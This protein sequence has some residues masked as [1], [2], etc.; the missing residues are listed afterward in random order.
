MPT[1]ETEFDASPFDAIAPT[2]DATFTDSPVGQAQRSAVWTE[3]QKAFHPGDQVLEIGCG[4]GVDACFLAE[5]GIRVLAC[6]SSPEMI[7]VAAERVDD[8][9]P[10]F[11]NASVELRTWRAEEIASL[12]PG[13]T[14][15]GAF[16]N[17]GALNC[18]HDL[19]HFAQQLG[20]RLRP[21]ASVLLCLMGPCCL[22]E[23]A[24]FLACG[25]PARAMRRLWKTGV[26]A[27]VGDNGLVR[28]YYPAICTIVRAFAPHFRLRKVKGIGLAIPPSYAASWADH[29]PYLWNLALKT[30]RRLAEV[31]GLRMLADHVLLTFE[32]VSA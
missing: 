2:Y 14:F 6:D 27:R 25:R 10:C 21:A 13:R 9:S 32:K 11:E 30:D 20:P 4:T 28:V 22:W 3:L 19:E 29:F 23:F 12:D 31:T 24:W 1:L 26:T 7:R 17:F 18:V 15:D 8:R 5:H 16:S